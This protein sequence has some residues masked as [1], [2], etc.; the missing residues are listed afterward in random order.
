VCFIQELIKYTKRYSYNEIKASFL[1]HRRKFNC[2]GVPAGILIGIDVQKVGDLLQ[3]TASLY[4][5][6]R[7]SVYE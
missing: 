5:E 4:L 1:E 7:N 3:G 6:N 2:I